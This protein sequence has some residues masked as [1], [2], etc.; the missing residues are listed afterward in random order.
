MLWNKLHQ[1]ITFKST[2]F[3]MR[4]RYWYCFKIAIKLRYQKTINVSFNGR[5]V[6]ES[7]FGP[8][9]YWLHHRIYRDF[10]PTMSLL[11][12]NAH[13]SINIESVHQGDTKNDHFCFTSSLFRFKWCVIMALNEGSL[14]HFTKKNIIWNK[15]G[16]FYIFF[17]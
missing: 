9:L 3:L 4:S 8:I 11:L 2:T 16:L 15:T 10:T 13:T 6:V 14:A 17:T 12:Y 5:R 7:I 1:K